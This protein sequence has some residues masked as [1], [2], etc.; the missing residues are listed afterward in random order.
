MRQQ[1]T[2]THKILGAVTVVGLIALFV[3]WMTFGGVEVDAPDDGVTKQAPAK[4][5]KPFTNLKNAKVQSVEKDTAVRISF[6]MADN[7]TEGLAAS[8]LRHDL[9]RASQEAAKRYPG[10]I[11]F[12]EAYAPMIDKYGE[13]ERSAVADIHWL[14]PDK[15]KRIDFEMAPEPLELATYRF[16]HPDLQEK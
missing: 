6:D 14:E 9:E 10:K 16:I 13:E 15:L 4:P 5:A 12:I 8:G 1:V 3:G 2:R 7:L 11:I